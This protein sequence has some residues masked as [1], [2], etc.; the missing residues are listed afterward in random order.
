M[1]LQ[2]TMFSRFKNWTVVLWNYK[3]KKYAP[4]VHKNKILKFEILLT[5]SVIN[6]V[7]ESYLKVLLGIISNHCDLGCKKH[8]I[9]NHL[10]L[11][12]KSKHTFSWVFFWR[13]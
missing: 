1:I 10:C 11:T 8:F 5:I 2:Y 4:N 7:F 9:S 12:K 3:L 6:S 13:L